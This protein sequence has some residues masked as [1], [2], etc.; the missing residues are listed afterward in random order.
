MNDRQ[1]VQAAFASVT[2]KKA[3]GADAAK[4]YRTL[5]MDAP[6]LLRQAGAIHAIAFWR[7]EV[8]GKEF[9][10]HIAKAYG[11]KDGEALLRQLAD[12]KNA[13]YVMGSRKLIEIA[14]WFRRFAQAELSE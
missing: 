3:E 12:S 6:V 9:S 7:R 11:A 14:G 4:R 13:D 8:S 5:C 2:G 10:N 1:Y